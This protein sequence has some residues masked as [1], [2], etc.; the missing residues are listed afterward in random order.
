LCFFFFLR[1]HGDIQPHYGY[2]NFIG[3]MVEG[4]HYECVS[5]VMS[6]RRGW[7][8]RE[9]EEEDQSETKPKK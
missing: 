9:E 6:R 7:K 4:G 2:N 5:Q 8:R 3:R 1:K